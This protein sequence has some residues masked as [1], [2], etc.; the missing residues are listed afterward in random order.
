[1]MEP[2]EITASALRDML[3]RGEPVTV[4]DIRR[5]DDRKDWSIPGSL[6]VDTYDALKA[7]DG[8]L[9][10]TV[11]YP[12]GRPVVTVCYRGNTSLLAAAE[13]CRRGIQAASLHGGMQ[14]WSLA[15]NTAEVPGTEATVV[16][17]RRTGKGCLSYVIGRDG[18]AAVIDASLDP[19][20]YLDLAK[21]RGWKI[22]AVFDTHVHAD[23]LSRSRKLAELCGLTVRLAD[24]RR[25]SYPFTAVRDGEMIPLGKS[26]I[27][28]LE[29]PGHT[30]GH[31][32]FF[33]RQEGILFAGDSILINGDSLRPSSGANTWSAQA[34]SESP[35]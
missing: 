30:P 18:V 8:S 12:A 4:L 3:D 33:L 17:V 10:D 22:T 28:V 24:Q 1:M 9:L 26:S 2:T 25:V 29:T 11:Q 13:L 35:C 27:K 21:Q 23:H 20:W 31:L 15:W 19:S 5:A 14:A 6:H 16:Q 7:N 32:S 34:A